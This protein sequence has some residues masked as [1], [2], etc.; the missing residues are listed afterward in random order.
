MLYRPLMW[1]GALV[2][3]ANQNVAGGGI[4]GALAALRASDTAG[5][6]ISVGY[7]LME[8]TRAALVDGILTLVISHS[9][10]RLSDEVMSG[11]IKALKSRPKGGT[12]TSVLP[13]DIYTRENI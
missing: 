12:F 2:S 9:L 8:N 3:A 1:P 5:K 7:Q 13:F 11:M 10:D 4:S 6:V